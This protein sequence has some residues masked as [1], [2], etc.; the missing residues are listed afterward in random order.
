M[1]EGAKATTEC[2][3]GISTESECLSGGAMSI[4][5]GACA[6]TCTDRAGS[7][8]REATEIVNAME[9]TTIGCSGSSVLSGMLQCD[10]SGGVIAVQWEVVNN[11]WP[12][13]PGV[14]IRSRCF[15]MDEHVHHLY[16]NHQVVKMDTQT[17][18]SV[19]VTGSPAAAAG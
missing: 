2:S 18:A 1:A 15:R 3:T 17:G 7:T 12:T 14:L 6:A 9:N 19:V 5:C 4:T 11:C 13:S 16:A 10:P 8:C